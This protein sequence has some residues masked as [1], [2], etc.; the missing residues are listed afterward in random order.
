MYL[1]RYNKNTITAVG[2]DFGYDYSFSRQLEAF[3][4]KAN[5]FAAIH[6]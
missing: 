4:Q 3:G 1:Q 6:L 2:N 5:V